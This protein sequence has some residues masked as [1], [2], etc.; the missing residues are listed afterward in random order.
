MR[1]EGREVRGADTRCWCESSRRYVPPIHRPLLPAYQ[2]KGCTLPPPNWQA[3]PNLAPPPHT[4]FPPPHLKGCTC[5][6]LRPYSLSH[7]NDGYSSGLP[8]T[9]V[10]P[11]TATRSSLGGKS[12]PSVGMTGEGSLAEGW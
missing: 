3:A 11:A 4:P 8:S 10:S 12:M 6:S 9:T 7:P 1:K 2:M 5:T